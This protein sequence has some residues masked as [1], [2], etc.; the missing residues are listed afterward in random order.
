MTTEHHDNIPSLEVAA[1]GRFI[2]VTQFKWLWNMTPDQ[3]AVITR[4][5]NSLAAIKS[6]G[7]KEAFIPTVKERT[8]N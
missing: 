1:L 7:L 3:L 8:A 2:S 4:F 5:T 6:A